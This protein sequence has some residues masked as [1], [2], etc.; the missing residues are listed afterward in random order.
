MKRQKIAPLPTCPKCNTIPAMEHIFY[1]ATWKNGTWDGYII[2]C[3]CKSI[4]RGNMH[5]AI[6]EWFEYTGRKEMDISAKRDENIANINQISKECCLPPAITR[7]LMS[8]NHEAY[9]ALEKATVAGKSMQD[10]LLEY[11]SPAELKKKLN[12]RIMKVSI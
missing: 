6:K 5:A 9:E 1:N 8:M 10:L 3:S 4:V 7:E 11:M 12:E 2:E